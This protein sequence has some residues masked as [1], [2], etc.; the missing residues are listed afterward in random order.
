MVNSMVEIYEQLD[1]KKADK[2]YILSKESDDCFNI[3]LHPISLPLSPFASVET[4]VTQTDS[5]KHQNK[6]KKPNTQGIINKQV[7]PPAS[8]L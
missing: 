6:S 1:R 3:K 7:H 4:S 2:E 8:H 5:S